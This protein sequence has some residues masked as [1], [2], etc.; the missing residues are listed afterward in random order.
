MSGPRNASL[1]AKGFRFYRWTD[2]VTGEETDVLSVTSI[3]KLCGEPHNLVSWKVANVVNLA[4]GVRK[5]EFIGPRGGQRHEYVQ[6]GEFPGE[7]VRR[8]VDS[9]GDT[10]EL[11]RVRGWLN[12]QADEPRDVAATRGTAVHAAIELGLSGT[13]KAWITNQFALKRLTPTDDDLEFVSDC[14][15][16]YR[17]LR[18]DVPFVILSQEPQCWNLTAGYAGSFDALVWM[19]P[20]ER[21][22]Q[23]EG[24]QALADEG[25]VDLADI[26]KVGGRIVLADW[27]TSSDV[28]TDHVTQVTAYL[29]SEFVG[30]DGVK[31]AR[32]TELLLAAQEG[33]LVHIRP[34]G[35]AMDFFDFD[36]ATLLA[37]LGS[38]AFARF[39][40]LHEK[41][42][43]LFKS[44]LKGQADDAV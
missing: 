11:A 20:E 26:Q 8:M 10:D 24:W 23:R 29:A 7:F 2:A 4:M 36:A 9:G 12:K 3:R 22:L 31:D 13:D 28:Y 19:L 41:P 42:T 25:K 38:C 43:A 33:A 21:A 39:L 14:M 16:Q 5:R 18:A 17:A 27:K 40:A 37:F 15:R 32:V 1:S 34:N 44:E 6:D 35:W 30:A